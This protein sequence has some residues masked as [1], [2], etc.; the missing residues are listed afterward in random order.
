M[1]RCALCAVTDVILQHLF[2]G[3][4]LGLVMNEVFSCSVRIV[5]LLCMVL[6]M[7]VLAQTVHVQD[8]NDGI[9]PWVETTYDSDDTPNVD[10][11]SVSSGSDPSCSPMEGSGMARFN[12]YYA[13]GGD[14]SRIR[15]PDLDLTGADVAEIRFWMYRD[16]GR[17]SDDDLLR[18]QM[19]ID[20]GDKYFSLQTYFRYTSGA[21]GWEEK[22]VPI[23]YFT[24]RSSVRVALRG[25]AD[26]GGNNIFVDNF[27]VTKSVLAAGVEGNDCTG[28]AECNSGV[29]GVDPFGS[30]RCRDASTSCIGA[31]REPVAAGQTLC[32]GLDLGTCVS[33][34]NW[35][36]TDCFNACDAYLDVHSCEHDGNS[37]QCTP[38]DENCVEL[39]GISE[40]CDDD[41]YCDFY[42]IG[43]D[44]IRK[45]TDGDPCDE[46][47]QCLSD[48]C[49]ASPQGQ[50]FCAPEG[51]NCV[52]NSGEVVNDGTAICA[53]GDRYLCQQSGWAIHDCYTN[54]GFYDDVDQCTDGVCAQCPDYCTGDDD[55]KP[56]IVCINLSCEGDLPLGST[57]QVA[58]QCG[59][60]YCVDDHCCQDLCSAPCY[61][62]DVDDSGIC[63]PI[64]SGQDP[65]GECSGEGVCAGACNGMGGCDYPEG[66]V[67]DVC[68]RCD[69]QGRCRNFVPAGTDPDDECPACQTCQGSQ[70]ACVAVPAGQDPMNDCQE[71][72]QYT[73]GLD[74]Q[75]DGQGACRKWQQGTACGA[76]SCSAG[77]EVRADVC[78]G[79]GD[80]VDGGTRQCAPYRCADAEHC[81]ESC[82]VHSACIASA[83]CSIS[84]TCEPDLGEGAPCDGVVYPGLLDD[85]ACMDGYCFDDNFDSTGAFCSSNPSGCVH[86]GDLFN[87]GYALCSGNDWYK[88]C[89]GGVDGWGQ[90]QSCGFGACDAGGGAG[91]GVRQA[92]QC[93]S[94]PGGGCSSEC[95]SCEP[96]MADDSSCRSSCSANS[97]CWP[98]YE[99]SDGKCILPEGI[100]DPCE[101]Q[102]DCTAGICVDGRCCADACDGP[103]EACNLPGKLGTCSPVPA[104]TDPDGDCPAED[105]G[106]CG[107]T[108][109]CDGDGACS[110]WP[111]GQVCRDA[112]CE[113]SKFVSESACDGAGHCIP[114]DQQDCAPGVCLASG[115]VSTCDSHDD[116][117]V[118]G[119]CASDG[120][121]Q[122]DLADGEDCSGVVF[123]G[124]D[125]DAAC[126]G[127]FCFEDGW[128]EQGAYCTGQVDA[129]VAQGISYQPGYSLCSDDDWF[130]T[131][132]GGQAGWGP[133]VDCAGPGVCDAGGGP[134]S[135][136]SQAQTC[137]SGQTGGCDAE[138]VSCYPFLA[139][140][141]GRC[142]QTCGEDADCWAGH[143]C[144]AGQCE[145]RD[146]LGRACVT[147]DDCGDFTCVDGVC[148]NLACD[149]ECLVCDDPMAAGVC[150]PAPFGTDPDDDCEYA[151]GCGTTGQ[152]DGMGQCE[153][154][155]A[156]T[157]CAASS[158]SDGIFVSPGLCNGKGECLD[159]LEHECPS[160]ACLGSSCAPEISDGGEQDADG[161][162]TDGSSGADGMFLIAEAGP[163]QVVGIGAQ[164]VLDGSHSKGPDGVGLNFSWEQTSGP[165]Q[166]ELSAST[167]QRASFV[168][169]EQGVYVFHLLVSDGDG[170]SAFDFT[171]VRVLSSADGCL[172]SHGGGSFSWLFV[173]TFVLVLL[174]SRRP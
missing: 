156:G 78:D 113:G 128:S 127:G 144:N 137:T 16:S 85:S 105:V 53:G 15:S 9:S 115:C 165:N 24:D 108:G 65:D 169:S 104:G 63:K 160:G 94:G 27:R 71:S 161:G 100:G 153:V 167:T 159:G 86:D 23:G 129:C 12:S 30:G 148:C 21:E 38:C 101:G 117:Q 81:A 91:S 68:T 7:P 131:C 19:S 92:G 125:D 173:F 77:T 51:Q 36:V 114:S 158:C 103:C 96:Y 41:A 35:S 98:S 95:V 39:F 45:K 25:R 93:N 118:S 33:A 171:E 60:G 57:C 46:D 42:L 140:A 138:C 102:S 83:Y 8:F 69:N 34:D 13:D 2:L 135:G 107:S 87:S 150:L 116:C 146:E 58:S 157:Q 18:L 5:F 97:D 50:K 166:V 43:G 143:V 10:W 1:F 37:Y 44:C 170:H 124:L 88:V 122:P 74:G 110:V 152:C 164:V 163:T 162:V 106:T 149:S 89:V 52:D 141:P 99:C 109:S 11:S 130:R 3:L 84:G 155:P 72:D 126:T 62:C 145:P 59:S 172:C 66:A 121:C 112:H 151:E 49:V 80:C 154:R 54:C 75:C 168:P 32:V 111:E 20:G 82:Q 28:G 142:A 14:E 133:R 79:Q 4:F 56:G 123:D 132:I 67:C 64:A 29:C 26:G 61:R 73:C 139:V 17:S 90:E 48:N 147:S 40:G 119:F 6:P 136:I 47:R 134:G 174:R 120:T 55:C 70:S 31:N 22:V 76:G